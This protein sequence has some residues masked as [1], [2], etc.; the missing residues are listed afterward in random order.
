[1]RQTLALGNDDFARVGIYKTD[2][3]WKPTAADKGTKVV[4]IEATDNYK[5][6]GMVLQSPIV[7]LLVFLCYIFIF[8]W[9]NVVYI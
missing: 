1:M 6:V 4:C 3:Y 8:N 2:M 5:Y 7:N 9:V